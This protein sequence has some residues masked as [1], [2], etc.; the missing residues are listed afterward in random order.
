MIH[1]DCFGLA[2]TINIVAGEVNQH[3]V[4]STIFLR[5]EQFLAQPFILYGQSK[6]RYTIIE[7]RCAPSAVSPR[8]VVPAIAWL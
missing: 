2:D 5:T 7:W 4:L 3:D 8:L 6:L 1:F